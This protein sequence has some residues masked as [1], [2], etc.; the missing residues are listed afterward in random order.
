MVPQN[1]SHHCPPP[2]WQGLCPVQT[3]GSY[4]VLRLGKAAVTHRWLSNPGWM[5]AADMASLWMKDG[6]YGSLLDGDWFWWFILSGKC[7]LQSHV[8]PEL[9]WLNSARGQKLSL[10]TTGITASPDLVGTGNAVL[11]NLD[12]L[13]ECFFYDEGQFLSSRGVKNVS[14]QERKNLFPSLHILGQPIYWYQP[15]LLNWVS[16]HGGRKNVNPLPHIA[17]C[18]F[19]EWKLP[20]NQSLCQSAKKA[21]LSPKKC[22]QTQW[23]SGMEVMISH[24]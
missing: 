7:W 11:G 17:I 9:R 3:L 19:P 23:K 6:R 21:S 13:M 5:A 4:T 2:H 16:W 14:T 20:F 22:I 12:K 15:F 10:F 18:C 8:S 24:W 1:Y